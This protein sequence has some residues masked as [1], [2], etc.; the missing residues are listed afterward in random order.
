M[1]NIIYQFLE[2]SVENLYLCKK[3]TVTRP[4]V[5]EGGDRAEINQLID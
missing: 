5:V 4:T 2:N 1:V 3:V